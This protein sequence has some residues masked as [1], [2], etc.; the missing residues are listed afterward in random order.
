M[1]KNLL[2]IFNDNKLVAFLLIGIISSYNSPFLFLLDYNQLNFFKIFVIYQYI[3]PLII[4]IFLIFYISKYNF[5]FKF[6]SNKNLTL[7]LFFFLNFTLIF[8]I[9]FNNLVYFYPVDEVSSQIS[10]KV[11]LDW[12]SSYT[13]LIFVINNLN[14]IFLSFVCFKEERLK[15]ILSFIIAALFI[16]SFYYIFKILYDYI[17]IDRVLYFYESEKLRLGSS[18]FNYVNPRSS[19][20]A[21]II[22]L[23]SIFLII[24]LLFYKFKNKF[25]SK[26]IKC[27]IFLLIIFYN[28]FIIQLQSRVSMYFL[29]LF[30]CL[31]IFFNIFV[32][33]Y[34]I[35][36][37]IFIIFSFFILPVFLSIIFTEYKKN[38]IIDYIVRDSLS[39]GLVIEKSTININELGFGSSSRIFDT[40]TSGRKNMWL[41]VINSYENIPL[42]GYGVLGDRFAY[43]FS[44]SNIFLYF[45]I[46]G[47]LAG[48]LIIIFFNIHLSKNILNSLSSMR[49]FNNREPFFY[50]SFVFILFF[51]FRSLV[52]NSY[53]QFSIDLMLLVPSCLIFEKYLRKYKVI[54]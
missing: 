27:F 32:K 29:Y 12:K 25:Y 48:F 10:G 5:F 1:F 2:N 8:G 49:L 37:I 31:F 14:I 40:T 19:G 13:R 39:K 16:I 6:F 20:L 52:E 23:I 36:K 42:L 51:L 34:K 35:K 24:F 15:F 7:K 46:S 9:F 22:L 54:T 43:S 38:K 44:V 47:G 4:L 41:K 50:I 33:I 11:F 21:R 18:T 45:L 17:N 53:G 26:F 30:L 28:F 3:S